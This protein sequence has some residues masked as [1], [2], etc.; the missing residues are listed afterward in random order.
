M[1]KS[2]KYERSTCL[3]SHDFVAVGQL[4]RRRPF[5]AENAVLGSETNVG[6]KAGFGREEEDRA[7]FASATAAA[8]VAR[9]SS[10]DGAISFRSPLLF[11]SR[12]K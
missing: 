12:G 3:L 8:A 2:E 6:S 11:Y 5:I 7:S 1:F 4:S 10:G 9:L